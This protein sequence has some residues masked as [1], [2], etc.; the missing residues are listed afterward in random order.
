MP[1][2]LHYRHEPGVRGRAD[3]LVCVFAVTAAGVNTVLQGVQKRPHIAS[4]CREWKAEKRVV[5]S[6]TTNPVEHAQLESLHVESRADR[7]SGEPSM[8][9]FGEGNGEEC[10][11]GPVGMAGDNNSIRRFE[12]S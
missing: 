3:A 8:G 11:H 9:A 7:A 1:Q 6:P 10:L 4:A 5:S 2:C 12:W